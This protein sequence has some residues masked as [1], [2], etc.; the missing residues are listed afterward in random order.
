MT[1][2]YTNYCL[3]GLHM[4]GLTDAMD[5]AV[6]QRIFNYVG[7]MFVRTIQHS[8]MY[9]KLGFQQFYSIIAREYLFCFFI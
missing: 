5:I 1:I 7:A 9:V 2:S 3:L 8:L 6:I 4:S